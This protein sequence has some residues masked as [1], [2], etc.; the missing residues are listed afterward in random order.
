MLRNSKVLKNKYLLKYPKGRQFV[1]ETDI[2]TI[3]A[4]LQQKTKS[5]RKWKT[6]RFQKTATTKSYPK[7]LLV[8]WRQFQA[9][10]V[11]TKW[12]AIGHL[13][14]IKL[15]VHR[16]AEVA[17]LWQPPAASLQLSHESLRLLLNKWLLVGSFGQAIAKDKLMHQIFVI[18][19]FFEFSLS[20]WQSF[21]GYLFILSIH[22]KLREFSNL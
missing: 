9:P 6:K 20:Y 15:K 11:H 10:G 12:P 4:L 7:R 18:F 5:R 16:S 17:L 8:F 13:T 22:P 3:N 14:V 19:F 2:I 21:N 1:S